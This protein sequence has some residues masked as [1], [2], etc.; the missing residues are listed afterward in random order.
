M[1]KL[2]AVFI[3]ICSLAYQH[4]H[5]DTLTDGVVRITDGDTLVALYGTS[6]ENKKRLQVV[7]S[8]E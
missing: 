6:L 2:P 5:A 8:P 7:D 1:N 3:L 4:A